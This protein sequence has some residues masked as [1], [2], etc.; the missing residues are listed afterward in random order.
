MAY[1]SGKNRLSGKS[2]MIFSV[3]CISL[4]CGLSFATTANFRISPVKTPISQSQPL[5][6]D[7]Y[8]SDA[9]SDALSDFAEIQIYHT[10]PLDPDT[11]DDGFYDG[12]E[13]ALGKDPLNRLSYPSKL[14]NYQYIQEPYN[15]TDDDRY[16]GPFGIS[17]VNNS[18]FSSFLQY[19]DSLHLMVYAGVGIF[20]FYFYAKIKAR[21]R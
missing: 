1:L 2:Y 17:T 13:V 14:D 11:D 21:R 5:I 16:T 15:S 6:V 10:D 3:L 12:L 7:F 18:P 8:D 19:F 20:C 9:D 4:I